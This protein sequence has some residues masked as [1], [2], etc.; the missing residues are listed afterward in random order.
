MTCP[1]VIKVKTPGPPGPSLQLTGPAVAGRI[2]GTG[3]LVS[4]P[5]GPG[6]SI[7]DGALV[8]DAVASSGTVTSVALSVPTGF[9]VSNS[10]ITTSG[11]LQITFATGYSL[12]SDA[13]QAEWDAKED[14]GAAASAVAAHEAAADPHPL[15]LTAAE[16]N[17]AY[18]TAA[19]GA[20]ADT[21]IQP[22]DLVSTSA[23]GL[24]PA[25]GFN[26]LTYTD[27]DM[28]A[29]DH[30]YKTLTLTG[31]VTFTSSNRANGRMVSIR[32]LPGASAR[33]LTFPVEW[34]FLGSKPATIAANKT[35]VLSLT[36]YGST[37]DDCVAAYAVQS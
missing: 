26:T 24:A 30:Q 3:N 17:F 35:A 7:V 19:Q 10:P 29:L 23:A 36:F 1:K 20:K 25:T 33:T 12:P 6:L 11:T 27:L 18:A 4:I 8:S 34:D 32:I 16:G 22:G 9:D 37:D 31:D 2:S 21:A 15:Y 13:K 28:A 5:L 14:S